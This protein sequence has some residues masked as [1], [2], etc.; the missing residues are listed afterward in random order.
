MGFEEQLDSFLNHLKV[1]RNLSCN[2]L[3]AYAS[4][5]GKLLDFAGRKGRRDFSQVTPMDLVGFLKKLHRKGLSVRKI[6]RAHV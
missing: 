5:I 3:E 2:T 6:G 1:E 4:D